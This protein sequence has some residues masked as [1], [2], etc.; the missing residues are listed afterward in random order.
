MFNDNDDNRQN[1]E[2]GKQA[3]DHKPTFGTRAEEEKP[4]QNHDDFNGLKELLWMVPS[5]F[6]LTRDERSGEPAVRPHLGA[7]EGLALAVLEDENVIEDCFTDTV[8]TD[9]GEVV[10]SAEDKLGTHNKLVKLMVRNEIDRLQT[11]RAFDQSDWEANS[12]LRTT[13]Q[14]AAESAIEIVYW[15]DAYLE[16][17]AKVEK[18]G[19][20]IEKDSW[21]QSIQG[22]IN[23]A[24]RKHHMYAQMAIA[25]SDNGEYIVPDTEKTPPVG[26][27]SYLIA[28]R[29]FLNRQAAWTLKK[30]K[31]SLST[32]S[33]EAALS[34]AAA[35]AVDPKAARRAE[36][37]AKAREAA[38][39]KQQA[40]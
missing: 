25:G 32:K 2:P 26:K 6:Y 21:A 10:E 39:K 1:E 3:L 22:F 28:A 33:K 24:I 31:T 36:L 29:S 18:K 35:R 19:G 40:A 9:T 14:A 8:D 5:T 15:K 20:D 23:N 4:A 16:Q 7:A 13:V 17:L 38:T 11:L 12:L 30:M 34:S 37:Y 27:T